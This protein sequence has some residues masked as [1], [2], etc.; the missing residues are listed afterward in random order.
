MCL[1]GW[2]RGD[3]RRLAVM[4]KASLPYRRGGGLCVQ[5]RT[6]SSVA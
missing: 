1:V 5:R 3:K 2:V 6:A 4:A